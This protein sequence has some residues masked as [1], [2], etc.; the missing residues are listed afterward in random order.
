M[1][2]EEYLILSA[3]FVLV[4][5]VRL[6]YYFLIPKTNDLITRYIIIIIDTARGAASMLNLGNLNLYNEETCIEI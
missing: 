6:Y 1:S 2:C 4:Y 3:S 5:N